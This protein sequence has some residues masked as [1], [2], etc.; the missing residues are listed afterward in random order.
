MKTTYSG[1]NVSVDLTNGVYVFFPDSGSGKSY[2][3]S[4]FR[5]LSSGR[6]RV[7]SYTYTDHALNIPIELVLDNSKFDIVVIDRYDLYYG[8][9]VENIVQFEKKRNCAC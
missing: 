2:L 5:D 1:L 4:V 6:L 7:A 3:A 9:G 8:V